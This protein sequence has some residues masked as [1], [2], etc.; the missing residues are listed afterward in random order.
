MATRRAK[1]PGE[2]EGVIDAD[3]WEMPL[4]A[5]SAPP[6][7]EEQS[8]AD[9][10]AVMLK[11]AAGVDR[12]KVAVYRIGENGHDLQWANNYSV[13]QFE[14][15]GD[16]QMIRQQFGAGRY[17]I[18]I[19]GQMPDSKR[20]AVL[21]RLDV[22]LL[23][24]PNPP[25]PAPAAQGL[26]GASELTQVLSLLA[27]RLTAPPPPPPDPMAQ[28]TAMLTMMKLMRE[29]V[30]PTAAPPPQ[31]SL[32]EQL[33][34]L[35]ALQ[36]VA[37]EL[38]PKSG[39][40][41]EPS[42]LGLGAEVMGMI[43]NHVQSRP[44]ELMLAPEVRLPPSLSVPDPAPP[45]ASEHDA[46]Q[47]PKE[48][49]TVQLPLDPKSEAAAVSEVLTKLLQLAVAKAPAEE[50]AA[51][52]CGDDEGN[53][54]LPEQMFDILLSEGWWEALGSVPELFALLKPHEAWIREVRAVIVR[55]MDEDEGDTVDSESQTGGAEM[56]GQRGP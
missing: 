54:G 56:I 22:D 5:T 53:P 48:E 10:I 2:S 33:T 39:G 9:R 4:A 31:K 34:E 41:E 13:D 1:P 27:E 47:T 46:P 50:G 26:S 37:G 15:G 40:A 32:V 42:L 24:D 51:L 45:P 7:E 20:I 19:Y 23:A 17:S 35:R 55:W 12:T 43:K 38:A 16:L 30:G 21:S 6:A 8:P 3:E 28:M 49:T 52:L 29:A 14:A 36:E 11:G 44:P 18:R 25:P